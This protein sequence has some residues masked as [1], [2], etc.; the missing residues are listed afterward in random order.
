MKHT[1]YLVCLVGVLTL[2]GCIPVSLHG[3]HEEGNTVYDPNLLGTWINPG[4][5]DEC[6]SFSQGEDTSYE[7]A[8]TLDGETAPFIVHLVRLEDSLFLDLYPAE[9]E[10]DTA[11]FYLLHLCPVH[12][13]LQVKQIGSTLKLVGLDIDSTQSLLEENPKEL[14]HTI[15]ADRLVMTASS[16]D[17]RRFLLRNA[18]NESLFVD[19]IEL[20]RKE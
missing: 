20:K 7:L 5:K 14:A 19:E 11:G 9:A 10:L 13:F 1:K 8:L 2:S 4:S 17:L 6:W 3:I 18:D 12:S 15:T 16:E